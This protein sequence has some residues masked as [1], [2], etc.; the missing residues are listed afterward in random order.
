[1]R[2][3]YAHS[4]FYTCRLLK[5]Y[6]WLCGFTGLLVFIGG[7]VALYSLAMQEAIPVTVRESVVATICSFVFVLVFARILQLTIG[8]VKTAL[9][10]RRLE[11]DFFDKPNAD[12]LRELVESYEI[13]RATGPDVPTPLYYFSRD[14]LQ[15]KWHE[16]RLTL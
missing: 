1:M 12:R 14:N 6:T 10:L 7:I 9:S 5:R 15:K 3:L 11:D 13:E 16:K 8:C 4:A 2:E